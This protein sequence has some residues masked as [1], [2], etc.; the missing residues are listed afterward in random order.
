[1]Q[2]YQICLLVCTEDPVSVLHGCVSFCG[3]YIP[4]HLQLNVAPTI[5]VREEESLAVAVA[6]GGNSTIDVGRRIL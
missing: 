4:F 5:F 1:M 6:A 2:F 3:C